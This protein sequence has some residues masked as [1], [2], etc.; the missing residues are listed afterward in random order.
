M[1]SNILIFSLFKIPT[2]LS[3]LRLTEQA[4]FTLKEIEALKLN[5]LKELTS[6]P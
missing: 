2:N 3:N 1:I 4:C 6:T 5:L